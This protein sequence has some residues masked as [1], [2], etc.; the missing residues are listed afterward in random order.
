MRPKLR[1]DDVLLRTCG[2]NVFK[3]FFFS[4]VAHVE[5]TVRGVLRM[6]AD[7]ARK[8]YNQIPKETAL[9]KIV[10]IKKRDGRDGVVREDNNHHDYE[11]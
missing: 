1:F 8:Y 11:Q 3:L 5:G 4:S 10:L 2:K 7:G 6:A 9:I